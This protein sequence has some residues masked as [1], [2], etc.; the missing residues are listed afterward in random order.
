MEAEDIINKF[1]E[2]FFID[3]SLQEKENALLFI[4]AI[5]GMALVYKPKKVLYDFTSDEL[6]YCFEKNKNM[7]EDLFKDLSYDKKVIAFIAMLEE[8]NIPLNLLIRIF[9]KVVTFF[10]REIEKQKSQSNSV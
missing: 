9:E 6:F 2:I 7:M 5:G 8:K 10:M 1:E 3:G 4:L